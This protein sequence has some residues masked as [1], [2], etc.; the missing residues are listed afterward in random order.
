MPKPQKPSEETHQLVP[1]PLVPLH[2]R[3]ALQHHHQDLRREGQERRDSAPI[4]Q[5]ES[6]I[7]PSS[8]RIRYPMSA[9]LFRGDFGNVKRAMT[10]MLH[11]DFE[12][13]HHPFVDPTRPEGYTHLV[14]DDANR[15]A[16]AAATDNS[17]KKIEW[18]TNIYGL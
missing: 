18:R 4:K 10:Q 12:D 16:N 9:M 7:C 14:D 1:K 8:Y 15:Q 13:I 5:A 11:A 6:P 17:K 2:R 3:G